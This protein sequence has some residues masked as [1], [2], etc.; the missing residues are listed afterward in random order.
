[1]ICRTEQQR[2]GA[3]RDNAKALMKKGTLSSKEY[4]VIKSA[5]KKRVKSRS[6]LTK[7]EHFLSEIKSE[8]NFVCC[9]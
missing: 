1:M 2:L 3:L 5:Y 6:K 7:E 4:E 8:V 9:F